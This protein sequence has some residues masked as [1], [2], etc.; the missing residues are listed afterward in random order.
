LLAYCDAV[1]KDVDVAMFSGRGIDTVK[2]WKKNG[3]VFAYEAFREKSVRC[4][5]AE[6]E[7]GVVDAPP[8]FSEKLFFGFCC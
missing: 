4:L 5:V 7:K 3:D 1:L 6:Y 2:A 8:I